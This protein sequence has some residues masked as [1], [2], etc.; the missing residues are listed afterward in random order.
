MFLDYTQQLVKKSS[1][2]T[3]N[4]KMKENIAMTM[5]IAETTEYISMSIALK[6]RQVVHIHTVWY[7]MNEVYMQVLLNQV[8]KQSSYG[9]D[10]MKGMITYDQRG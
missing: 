8:D 3:S 5:S 6:M 10:G 2:S 1:K 4:N 9:Y 7:N